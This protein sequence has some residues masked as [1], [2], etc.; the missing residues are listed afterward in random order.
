MKKIQ[1][2]KEQCKKE[3]ET[4]EAEFNSKLNTKNLTIFE[5]N[6]KLQKNNQE[7]INERNNLIN[8]FTEYKNH[9]IKIYI[10]L[11]NQN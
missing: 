9:M 8:F 2:L 10:I 1:L 5:E 11:E 4:R 6:A 3:Y 7:L